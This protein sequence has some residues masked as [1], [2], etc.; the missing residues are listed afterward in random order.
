MEPKDYYIGIHE[1]LLKLPKDDMV[2]FIESLMAG[3][4]ESMRLY[5]LEIGLSDNEIKSQTMREISGV[6]KI[7][8]N[9]VKELDAEKLIMKRNKSII[10][11]D[12][13]TNDALIDLH[14]LLDS[15]SKSK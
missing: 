15:V 12:Q 4:I 11:D 1:N 14:F 2:R 6:I 5:Y 10:P 9:R 13:F 3:L 7:I 8:N